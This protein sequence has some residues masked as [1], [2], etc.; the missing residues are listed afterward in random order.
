MLLD[1]A[2]G[3]S[4]ASVV[5]YSQRPTKSVSLPWEL[6]CLIFSFADRSTLL[7]LCLVSFEVLRVAGPLLYGEIELT[8]WDSLDALFVETDF[9]ESTNRIFPFLSLS[10]T[11]HLAITTP[12]KFTPRRTPHRPV[13]SIP[14]RLSSLPPLQLSSFHL[15]N[16]TRSS[17]PER[18]RLFSYVFP[19]VNPVHFEW[20]G[21]PQGDL[22]VDD[23]TG[24]GVDRWNRLR[25]VRL[26]GLFPDS[27]APSGQL[28]FLFRTLP[29][30]ASIDSLEESN[31]SIKGRSLIW[32][33]K[34]QPPRDGSD[35]FSSWTEAIN[36]LKLF[37]VFE[38]PSPWAE[39][40]R[41][42]VGSERQKDAALET[43]RH[44][45]SEKESGS[46]DVVVV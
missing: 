14:T 35:W 27:I 4:E 44:A 6:Y 24:A 26:A 20:A 13:S 7:A 36:W 40:V 38:I 41:I 2:E 3:R 16:T 28:Q 10:N 45:L 19:S 30:V 1:E 9:I 31:N 46:I 22:E 5:T 17:H 18:F 8:D 15:R 12:P 25:T 33:F 21:C 11:R 23:R 29:P 42:E 34:T 37:K 39:G 43:I 32:D